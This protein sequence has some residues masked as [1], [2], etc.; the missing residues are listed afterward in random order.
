MHGIHGIF[1]DDRWKDRYVQVVLS[2]FAGHEGL[3]E[4]WQIRWTC[5]GNSGR[6]V[7]GDN[8][9]AHT[10]MINDSPQMPLYDAGSTNYQG[11]AGVNIK[12]MRAFF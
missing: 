4:K 3:L 5:Y 9:P 2:I 1:R 6:T 7:P 8:M 10:T 11:S 12:V